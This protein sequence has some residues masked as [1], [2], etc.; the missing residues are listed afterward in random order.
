[1]QYEEL[2]INEIKPYEKNP[3]K[4]DRAVDGVAE[5]IKQFG[6]KQPLVIDKKNVIVAG[7]TRY[8]AAKKLGLEK[9]PVVRADD[10]TAKQVKAYRILDNKLSEQSYWDFDLLGAELEDFDFDF[11]DEDDMY[12][13]TCPNCNNTITTDFDVIADGTLECPNCGST[14]EFELDDEEE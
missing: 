1:M 14:I 2:P 3:R 7:H 10:L 8:K 9:V 6:F 12:E 4:N 11:D 5:S 13:I